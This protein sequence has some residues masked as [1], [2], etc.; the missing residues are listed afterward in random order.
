MRVRGYPEL[1]DFSPAAQAR[2]SNGLGP[3]APPS[4]SRRL[5]FFALRRFLVLFG[6]AELFDRAA[7]RHDLLYLCGGQERHRADVDL[8]FLGDCL[9]EVE[10]RDL[11]LLRRCAATS[12][13]G[14][15]Y[16]VV[17]LYG[18]GLPWGGTPW[19]SRDEPLA[20]AQVNFMA[21]PALP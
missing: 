17:R 21:G 14:V 12:L 1:E 3:K 13:A 5:L 4:G 18:N 11:P 6:L 8:I 15:A 16:G 20:A 19:E 10:N 9:E 2:F 7:R